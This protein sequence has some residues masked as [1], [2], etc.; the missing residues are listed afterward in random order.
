VI[1]GLLWWCLCW[2][3]RV[4]RPVSCVRL[5]IAPHGNMT[6]DERM[7]IYFHGHRQCMGSLL[8]CPSLGSLLV[9]RGSV[10]CSNQ[11]WPTWNLCFVVCMNF[12]LRCHSQR[13][14]LFSICYALTFRHILPNFNECWWNRIIL[15]ILICD[16]TSS[17]GLAP[18]WTARN[19]A[20]LHF[21]L[22]RRASKKKL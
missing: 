12:D 2:H 21:C 19:A 15:D 22:C 16:C 18:A 17:A 14:L 6:R 5:P 10:I 11:N 13:L 4:G 8:I 20:L 9:C 3:C 1:L 7:V